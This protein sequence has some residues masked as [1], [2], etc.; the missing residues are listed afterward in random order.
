MRRAGGGG[1]VGA[2]RPSPPPPRP[3][4]ED[5]VGLGHVRLEG[6]VISTRPV[7]LWPINSLLN[8]AK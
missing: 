7:D 5:P 1:L 4:H 6:N 8:T 2:V 3:C